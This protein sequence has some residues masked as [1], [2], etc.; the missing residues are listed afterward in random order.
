MTSA[1]VTETSPLLVVR[2][3]SHRY[4]Q[5]HLFSSS[6]APVQ[7]FVDIDLV[8]RRHT[9]IALVGESGAGKSSL[10]RC[11]A[12]LEKPTSGEIVFD[13]LKMF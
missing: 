4:G 1:P 2:K 5:N 13:G 8:L 3:L 10:A 6:S 12:L 7:A 11:L 9:T